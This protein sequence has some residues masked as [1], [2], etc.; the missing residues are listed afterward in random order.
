MAC[1]HCASTQQQDLKFEL[2]IVFPDGE[3]PN[4]SPIRIRQQ[5]LVCV[6]CAIAELV[7]STADLQKIR[8]NL[9]ALNF[10]SETVN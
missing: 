5:T 2:L 4:L 9:C 10:D 7:L 3:R 1:K 6:G 8:K